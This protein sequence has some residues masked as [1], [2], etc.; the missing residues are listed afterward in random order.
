MQRSEEHLSFNSRLMSI[1]HVKLSLGGLT[2]D[3]WHT[4]DVITGQLK[5]CAALLK[6]YFFHFYLSI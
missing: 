2:S 5:F 6:Y 4:R 3:N 1:S